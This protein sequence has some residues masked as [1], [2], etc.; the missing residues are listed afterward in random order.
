[1]GQPS[2]RATAAWAAAAELDAWYARLYGLTR[3]QLRYIL[4]PHGLSEREL[5]N[6]PDPWEHPTCH[7]PY[8]QHMETPSG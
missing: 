4:D 2:S 5:Q 8:P 1:M 3:K 7:G 6:T